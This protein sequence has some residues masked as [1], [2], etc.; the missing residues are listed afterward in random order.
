MPDDPAI[1]KLPEGP[2][3]ADLGFGTDEG[4]IGTPVPIREEDWRDG[5][6]DDGEQGEDEALSLT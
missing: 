6:T 4:V 1:K 2:R 5:P 3:D